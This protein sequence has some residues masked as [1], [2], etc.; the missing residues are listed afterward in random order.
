MQPG[1]LQLRR[2]RHRRRPQQGHQC[3]RRLQLRLG[4]RHGRGDHGNGQLRDGSDNLTE[5]SDFRKCLQ[6]LFVV[7]FLLLNVTYFILVKHVCPNLEQAPLGQTTTPTLI[8][9][10]RLP[11]PRRRLA[12]G[13]GRERRP[14]PGLGF[15]TLPFVGFVVFQHVQIA[16]KIFII[17]KNVEN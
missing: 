16:Y 4:P 7:K 14:G 13:P 3:H 10:S 11:T 9:R 15:R 17:L 2:G 12:G 5:M 8:P 6:Q 1:G